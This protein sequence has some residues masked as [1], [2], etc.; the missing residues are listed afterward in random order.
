M[1]IKELEK[2]VNLAW[3]PKSQVPILLAAGPTAQSEASIDPSDSLE[4]YSL[5][6]GDSS[7]DLDLL[8][9]SPSEHRYNFYIR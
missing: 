5:N 7:Y 3:S 6:L 2:T 8:S 9:S 1:K 4:L